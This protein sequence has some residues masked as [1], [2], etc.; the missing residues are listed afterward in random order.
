MANYNN[1]NSG[2]GW[3]ILSLFLALIIIA[4]VITGVVFWQKGN[5]VFNPIKQEQPHE[6][7]DE[8]GGAVVEDGTGNG[9]SVKSV[10]IPKAEYAANGISPL[11]ETAYT[12]T[13]T[14]TPAN[15]TNSKVDWAGAFIDASSSWAAGKNFSDYVTVTPE[16]DGSLKATVTCLP[17]PNTVTVFT[18][19]CKVITGC[20]SMFITRAG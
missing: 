14:V 13:A 1:Y 15:A 20:M 18:V 6:N 8:N 17:L 16:S 10:K 19:I 12:L 9:V 11:A 4:G 7:P 2:I 5:I 3:K